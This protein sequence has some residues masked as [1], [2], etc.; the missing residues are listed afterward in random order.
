MTRA[1]QSSI[2]PANRPMAERQPRL[3]AFL[4]LKFGFLSNRSV[5]I[6]IETVNPAAQL[7]LHISD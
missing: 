1:K 2:G 4:L 3:A 6:S 7:N 5:T